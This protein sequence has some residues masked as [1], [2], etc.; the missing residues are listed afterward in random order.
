MKLQGSLETSGRDLGSALLASRRVT[1]AQLVRAQEL[2]RSRGLDLGGAL[3]HLGL[4]DEVDL[5]HHV[6]RRADP[7]SIRL[8]PS[9]VDRSVAAE[10]GASRS[11]SLGAVAIH[12]IAG[13]VTVA[14]SQP[15]DEDVVA[16][17]ERIFE[18]TLFLVRARRAEVEACLEVLFPRG[19]DRSRDLDVIVNSATLDALPEVVSAASVEDEDQPVVQLIQGLLD[20]AVEARA[21][22]IHFEPR[23]NAFVV[24]FRVDGVLGE[25]LH[26]DRRW[27]R[28]CLSRLKIMAGLDIAQRRLPQDGRIRAM[29][30]G[31]AADLRLATTP[32]LEEEAAVLRLL[33]GSRPDFSIE[34]LGLDARQ[35]ARLEEV[36]RLRDGFVLATG[37]TGSGKTTTLYGMLKTLNTPDR[38]IVTL[39]DPVE[40][41]LDE[42]IQINANPRIG[43]GFATALRSVLRLDPDVILVG[44]IRDT[45]TAHIAVQAALTGHLVLSSLSASG[46]V[47]TVTRLSDMG[48]EPYL[49]ADT[50]RAVVSQRLLRRI[51]GHCREEIQPS[52]IVLDALGLGRADGPFFSGRGCERCRNTGYTGRV[53]LF[54]ILVV[55]QEMSR[56]IA[57]KGG[58]AA[59][60]D[61]AGREGLDSMRADGLRK[62]RAGEVALDEVYGVTAGS[63]RR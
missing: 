20:E 31:R 40:N 2:R 12:R 32:A 51:C 39:E 26:L 47:E 45:E 14:L 16:A 57:S 6:S 15:H 25:R 41:E 58:A 19:F 23:R 49:L 30:K 5:A 54:E 33:S 24:R 22:D 27:L 56:A 38:R 9:I 53:P 61:L 7:P 48:I 28:P 29:V 4:V 37:P 1:P 17:L 59:L 34:E 11:R 36:I 13:V 62:V 52:S 55:G 3:L 18:G 44:E 42:A 21:S 8:A 63:C 50:L 60:R 46:T 35:R 43:L 10:L